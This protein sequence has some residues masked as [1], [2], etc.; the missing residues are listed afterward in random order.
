MDEKALVDVKKAVRMAKECIAELYQDE[1]ILHLGLEE[2]EFDYEDS[3]WNITIGFARARD[4]NNG[5]DPITKDGKLSAR[6]YKVVRID[7]EN[8][9]VVSIRD[10]FMVDSRVR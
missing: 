1:E 2:V 7:E 10:R 9:S 5:K 3:K 8:G 6:N 4:G